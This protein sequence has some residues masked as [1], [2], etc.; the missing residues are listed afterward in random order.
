MI[1]AAATKIGTELIRTPEPHSGGTNRL[2]GWMIS[3]VSRALH[4]PRAILTL[5]L[6]FPLLAA[7]KRETMVERA[8]REGILLVGNSAEP[9][10]LDLQIVTG[11]PENKIISALFE[12]LVGDHP[13]D[14]EAMAPG[15]ATHWEHN[16]DMTE[17]TFHLRPE[18]KWS[19]GAPLTAEDFIFSYHRMLHPE[20][21]AAYAPMLHS[22]LNAETYNRD[23]RGHILCG[24]DEDFPTPWETLRKANFQGDESID[25]GDRASREFDSLPRDERRL[26]LASKGLDRLN[27]PQLRAIRDDP[28]LFGWPDDIPQE[29]RQ[30]VVARLLAHAEAGAPDLFE[31]AKIGLRAPDPH[32]LVVTLREPVPYLPSKSRHST[33]FPVPKH[34]ILKHGKMTERFTK[35]ATVGNLVGNGPFQLHQW[36]YNHY[37]EV[38][39]NPHYWEAQNVGLNGIRFFPIENPYTETRSFL[40][41]QLHTTYNLPPDLLEKTRRDYPQYLRAE[42]YVGTTFVRLNTTRP[43]LDDPRV[44]RALSLA[45]HREELCKYIYE[46][47]TPAETYTPRLGDYRPPA[48]LRYDLDEAK[49][50]LAEAGYPNGKGLPAYALL[51]SRMN[52]GVD[53][54]QQTFRNLGIRLTVEQK[55]WGSYIAAQQSLNF[56]I[57]MAGWIGDYLDPTT[58]LDMWT[59]NNG[60]NNTGWDSPEYE[61]LL[62]KAARQPNPQARLDILAQAE[63]KLME[64]M[65]FLPVAWYSR[66]YLHRPEV[67][68]W[69]PLVLDNH[70]WKHITLQP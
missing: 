47:F 21:A 7:C 66:L 35:W 34:V 43:G 26:L 57:A 64:E 49:A 2:A 56:D 70:P 27:A 46:G 61:A 32:T 15:V 29:T 50:L 6:I 22:I 5:C 30:R 28:A 68:G 44:R 65:P 53:A 23:E 17:W 38:R 45:I 41:G 51:T 9:R 8:N 37:I 39:R 10:A 14:D 18:A 60:N 58:F 36:R 24:L 19:D 1:V 54:M 11:V 33:W 63:G 16:E 25:A 59:R 55:D 13:S 52:A 69:H 3:L 42:P 48:V 67:R 12:G 62:R 20:L 31:K 4:F 40:A